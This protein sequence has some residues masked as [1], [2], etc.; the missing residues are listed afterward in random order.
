[1]AERV[2]Q[3]MAADQG[4]ELEIESFGVSSEES[5][6]PIDP[7]A[8]RALD[9]AGYHS[10]GHRAR[11]ISAADIASADL[12]VAAEPYHVDRLR[13]L[14][15]DADNLRLLNDYNPAY[16]KGTPLRD[17]W[18]GHA[19]DFFDTLADVEA[20]MPAILAEFA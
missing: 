7:R 19:E 3:G 13:Q 18:Y 16:P 14:A 11:R 17:P 8:R 1:M 20:A 2:A 9:G 12:V 6:H 5:G 15:P 4:L 10:S